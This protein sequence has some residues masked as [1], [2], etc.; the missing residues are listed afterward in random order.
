MKRR[1]GAAAVGLGLAVGSCDTPTGESR[2][3]LV[4]VVDTDA[5]VQ[6]L[7]LA[8]PTLNGAASIDTVRVD[9]IP[10]DGSNTAYDLRT[11]TAPSAED[12]PLSFGVATDEAS[13]EGP[14]RLRIRA[15][16]GRLGR[17]GELSGE[18]TLDPPSTITI[19]R[20]IEIDPPEK[21]VRTVHVVLRADCTGVPTFF[22]DPPTTCLDGEAG[23]GSPRD[24]FIDI[25]DAAAAPPTSVGSWEGARESPC[26]VAAP[27]GVDAVCVPGGLSVLGD[28][29]LDG[30]SEDFL[31]AVPL[32]PVEISPFHLDRLE[33][34]VGRYNAIARSG[35]L[36]GLLAPEPRD[37]GDLLDR[38]CTWLGVDDATNDDLPLNCISNEAAEAI[39]AVLGGSLPSEAQWEHAARGRGRGWLYPWGDSPPQCCTASLSRSG[40]GGLVTECPG[41]GIEPAGSHPRTEAC[42]GV[43]DESLD[44]ILDL[45]GSLTESL[46]DAPKHF[47]DVCWSPGNGGGVA[48]DPVCVDETIFTRSARGGYWNAG[49]G[50][51]AVVLRNTSAAG[52]A[53]GFRCA[54]PGGA[55]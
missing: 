7:V 23:R 13:F 16:A 2:P 38:Y 45:G 17:A 40:L 12:W 33:M 21:G 44:G 19:D 5:V 37:P 49:L 26:S 34:T 18:A 42:G 9:A 8:D 15:F 46:R 1:W 47:D 22:T 24:G 39:C 55:R 14:V 25:V 48:L 51:A 50:T 3:Q 6:G 20:L 31:R 30:F 28:E 10:S 29:D 36:A 52:P 53:N 11:F 54:Y 4:V 27:A 43:G 35:R 32:Q 41:E